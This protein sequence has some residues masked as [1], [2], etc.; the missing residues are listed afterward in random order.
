[1]K[2]S[3]R[4]LRH[5]LACVLIAVGTAAVTPAHAQFDWLRKVA[6]A[7]NPR[8]AQLEEFSRLY[9][10]G[11]Y[12]AAATIAEA[13]VSDDLKARSSPLNMLHSNHA[14]LQQSAGM[15]AKAQAD[16]KNYARALE[17]L[18]LQV[19]AV[20][21]MARPMAAMSLMPVRLEMARLH[22]LLQQPQEA[23]AIYQDLLSS[24]L[25]A[26]SGMAQE[27]H[28][29]LG[30]LAMQQGDWGLAEQQLLIAIDDNRSAP[31]NALA[32]FSELTNALAAA[33]EMAASLQDQRLVTDADGELLAGGSGDVI[34]KELLAL[35]SPQT[36]LAEVYWRSGNR[37][38]LVDFYQAR[39]SRYA[40]MAQAR[41]A[42][43]G[44]GGTANRKLELQYARIGML[45]AAAGVDDLA[46][47]AFE[48]ALQLNATRLQ[49]M[50]NTFLP[51]ALAASLRAR[52]ELLNLA[53]SLQLGRRQ[54]S[55]AGEQAWLGLALQAKGLHG[56]LLAERVHAVAVSDD[57]DVARLWADMHALQGEA[58]LSRR[59][60]LSVQL[61]QRLAPAL[62]V[63][64]LGQGGEFLSAVRQRLQGARLLSVLVYTPF[65]FA[66]Q[67]S[68][69][70]RYLGMLVGAQEFKAA[71]LGEAAAI[72]RQLTLLR[73]E[74]A[75]PPKSNARP[76][77]PAAARALYQQLLQPLAGKQLAAGAYIA[78]L[79]GALG[80]LPLEALTDGAGRYLIDS[81]EWRYV[82]SARVLLRDLP[83]THGGG[84]ALVMAS[85]GFD[86]A[87]PA[88]A[89]P[90][91]RGT[92][93]PA[94][95]SLRFAALPE[96][97][98]EGRLV[99]AA[100]GRAGAQVELA[101]GDDATP[102]RLL[103]SHG[104]RYLHIASHGFFLEEA[105]IEL[106][107]VR[108]RD[109]RDYTL[110]TVN[111]GL[112][113]GI[114]LAG[115]N[116]S[117]GGDGHGEGLLL[118]AQLRQLDLRGTELAVLSACET[119]VGSPR[120]GESIES[121]RQA[122]EVAGARS[123]VTSL[124][125]VASAETRDTMVAFY[126][127][128]GKGRGKA[129]ALRQAKLAIKSKQAHPFYWAPFIVSG[130]D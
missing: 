120:I 103:R 93:S 18:K 114:A 74:L 40:E 21:A 60:E 58:A 4:P 84:Q 95:R 35:E 109:G 73:A 115:A 15:A 128:L 101:S 47:P 50:Q 55:P 97:L 83:A 17:L 45:L 54:P 7:A 25:L 8:M 89:A 102:Q 52:R 27:V 125:R 61:Q 87:A 32:A 79:D 3:Y 94:L 72:D 44:L 46:A 42:S 78:D 104:P 90:A 51:E 85:P 118:T 107:D 1:M 130:A 22:V 77:V 33:R 13:L 105:G 29:R 126:E 57:A 38:A 11:D 31:P 80:L 30:R 106:R 113:G 81:T 108:G 39:F 117:L 127:Q 119:G 112:S 36:D 75:T 2:N 123:S 28:A 24:P 49:A 9:A 99:A 129:A 98:E 116:R 43:G 56:E 19:D 10:M 86:A 111:N 88:G 124:W 12:V 121:L 26:P 110:A 71:D 16:A 14:Q 70:P 20:P 122:L 92:L 63:A 34:L 5:G 37:A 91:L 69:T 48:R 6:G 76:A 65:D 66:R 82:S 67:A 41:A 23:R 100:L 62:Q 53:L 59:S 68:G 64:R 96:T